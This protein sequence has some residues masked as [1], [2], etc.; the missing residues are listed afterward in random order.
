[1]N[2]AQFHIPWVGDVGGERI[3]SPRGSSF[4]AVREGRCSLRFN[5][6]AELTYQG[7]G[8]PRWK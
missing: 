4:A 6:G 8:L 5:V 2:G 1:M 7:S 3:Q